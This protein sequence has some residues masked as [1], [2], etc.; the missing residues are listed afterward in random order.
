MKNRAIAIMC[1]LALGWVGTPAA[2]ANENSSSADP[3]AIVVDFV[4]VRPVCL[5]ATALGSAFFVLSLPIASISKSVPQTADA[6][7]VRP[8]Q[9]TFTRPLGDMDS[10]SGY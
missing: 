7:V 4:L 6:L 9:A 5:V 1:A 2:F 8:A 10:L 3:A